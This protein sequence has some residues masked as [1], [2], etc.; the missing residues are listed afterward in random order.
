MKAEIK[1]RLLNGLVIVISAIVL[2]LALVASW[3][4]M[5]ES[6]LILNSLAMTS[7]SVVVGS[8][9]IGATLI[10]LNS[11]LIDSVMWTVNTCW[12]K[13]TKK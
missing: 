6:V 8:I 1:A 9:G 7:N 11:L 10:W 12:N 3:A 13:G 5:H 2:M 4:I